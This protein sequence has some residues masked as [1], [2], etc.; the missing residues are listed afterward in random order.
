MEG[1]PDQFV[2]VP[3][4][5]GHLRGM[6]DG[7]SDAVV[8]EKRFGEHVGCVEGADAYRDDVVEGRGGADIDEA[9]GAGDAGHY[10]YCV[11]GNCRGGL[12]LDIIMRVALL[13][14][15]PGTVLSSSGHSRVGR[16]Y[17]AHCSPKR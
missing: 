7:A 16:T 3:F 12:D 17:R 10:D 2:S 6:A 15:N 9:D 8:E 5:I 13:K 14:G 11:E 1:A 4:G